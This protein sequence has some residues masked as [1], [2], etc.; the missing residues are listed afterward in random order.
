MYTVVLL[1]SSS[2]VDF[3]QPALNG[4]SHDIQSIPRSWAVYAAARQ[5]A[6]FGSTAQCHKLVRSPLVF[7]NVLTRPAPRLHSVLHHT[8]AKHRHMA[9]GGVDPQ[10]ALASIEATN[11]YG[12]WGAFV[13]SVAMIIATELGDKTFFIAA[14]LAMQF[15]RSGVAAFSSRS[16]A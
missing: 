13:N 11:A 14:I 3:Q 4:Q 8:G 10:A 16:C 7:L 6:N 1:P 9:D 2:R 12:F 5:P 15:E